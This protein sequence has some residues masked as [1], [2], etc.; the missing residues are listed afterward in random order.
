MTS[1]RLGMDI[2]KFGMNIETSCR[3][4][5]G[6]WIQRC[7]RRCPHQCLWEHSVLRFSILDFVIFEKEGNTTSTV[8]AGGVDTGCMSFSF[9]VFVGAQ[10]LAVRHLH[11]EG[12]PYT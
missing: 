8:V 10:K 3:S 4:F 5:S 12:Y 7:S 1:R 2:E 9:G 6:S 11:D